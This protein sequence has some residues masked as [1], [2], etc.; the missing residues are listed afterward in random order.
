MPLMFECIYVN[1]LRFQFQ[2]IWLT[3]YFQRALCQRSF[4]PF[5]SVWISCGTCI[6]SLYSPIQ[7]TFFLDFVSGCLVSFLSLE[8][9]FSCLPKYSPVVSSQPLEPPSDAF[10]QNSRVWGNWSLCASVVSYG[11]IQLIHT[12]SDFRAQRRHGMGN[13]KY[14]N[15]LCINAGIN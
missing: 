11:T 1:L 3:F 8:T 14:K 2:I 13:G 10:L 12:L 6:W 9:Y 5:P 15:C 7:Q 4:S